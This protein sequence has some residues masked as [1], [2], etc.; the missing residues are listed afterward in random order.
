MKP[1]N[2][3]VKCKYKMKLL[4]FNIFKLFII[5]ITLPILLLKKEWTFYILAINVCVATIFAI[6]RKFWINGMIGIWL[7]GLSLYLN[8][9]RKQHYII[10]FV[11][12]YVVWNI[13]FTE[14]VLDTKLNHHGILTSLSMNLIPLVVFMMLIGLNVSIFEC[15]WYFLFVR[16]ILILFYYIHLLDSQ[17]CHSS[18]LQRFSKALS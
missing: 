10:P 5:V 13:Y 3:Y 6:S 4:L 1:L 18:N 15:L 14:N 2:Y 11:F 12:A 7:T 17:S 9:H 8:T 16:C